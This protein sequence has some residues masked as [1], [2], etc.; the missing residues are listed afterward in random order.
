LARFRPN[1]VVEF[2]GRLDFQV[3]VR[4]FRIE[5][6][7]I[8]HVLSQHKIVKEAVVVVREDDKQ[9]VRLVAYII[10]ESKIDWNVSKLRKFLSQKLPDYMIP[11]NL[12]ELEALPLTPNGK[13]DRKALPAPD[14]LRPELEATYV[15]PRTPVEERIAAIWT[16]ILGLEQVGVHDNF[17]DLGGHS[18]LSVRL[19]AQIE[20]VFGKKLPL[21]A[22]FPAQT[23]EKLANTLRQE[24]APALWH[25][26][27]PLQ[28]DVP[29]PD[30]LPRSGA[31]HLCTALWARVRDFRGHNDSPRTTRGSGLSLHCR[32]ANRPA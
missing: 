24:E 29:H 4:G 18:L 31:T 3:K 15:P 19:I 30:S 8:E 1:G 27:V 9:D 32:D 26:L 16:E 13:L 25:S 28:P 17:F 5:L 14:N 12:I 10:P 21:A 2:L 20:K 11:S 23:I 7:E 22:L 6:V